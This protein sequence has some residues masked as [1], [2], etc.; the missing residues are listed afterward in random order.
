V[1]TPTT[2]DGNLV[3]GKPVR[4]QFSGYGLQR[5]SMPPGTPRAGASPTL[6]H[7]RHPTRCVERP[8]PLQVV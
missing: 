4:W 8:P 7:E 1:Q 5:R 3:D 6:I 2:M